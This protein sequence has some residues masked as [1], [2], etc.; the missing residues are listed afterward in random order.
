MSVT[1][2]DTALVVA[3]DFEGQ[4][5]VLVLLS[6]AE[7]PYQACTVSSGPLKRTCFLYCSM[8]PS[9]IWSVAASLTLSASDTPIRSCSATISLFR[10]I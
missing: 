3:L 8:Q 2:T 9:P 4:A 7:R 6:V 1:P 5:S 10:V